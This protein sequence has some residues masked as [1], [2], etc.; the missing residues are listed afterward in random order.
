MERLVANY[1]TMPMQTLIDN[2]LLSTAGAFSSSKSRRESGAIDFQITRYQVARSRFG[3]GDGISTSRE[4]RALIFA[5]ELELQTPINVKTLYCGPTTSLRREQRKEGNAVP[6]NL[7]APSHSERCVPADE[8]ISL[9][10]RLVLLFPS[11]R[12]YRIYAN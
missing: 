3:G 6:V 7:L 9:S 12:H 1:K 5:Q 11:L 8:V 10:R 4:N 2:T